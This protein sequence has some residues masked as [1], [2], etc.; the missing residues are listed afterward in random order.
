ML[1]L[2]RVLTEPKLTASGVW[3]T[4]DVTRWPARNSRFGSAVFVL[5]QPKWREQ[6]RPRERETRLFILRVLLKS[7]KIDEK[8]RSEG[9]TLLVL[10]S[11]FLFRFSSVSR[12]RFS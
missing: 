9:E 4:V 12:E 1:D 11:R 6:L 5:R 3:W 8:M 2:R 7:S 10:P